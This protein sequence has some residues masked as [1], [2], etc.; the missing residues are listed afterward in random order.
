MKCESFVKKEIFL[1][2]LISITSDA[3]DKQYYRSLTDKKIKVIVETK[4]AEDEKYSEFIDE[5]KIRELV[6]RYSDYIRYLIK[7]K[8]YSYKG[9]DVLWNI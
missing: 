2:E 4:S 6:K 7:I 5:Y 8:V 1:R 3:I 9:I